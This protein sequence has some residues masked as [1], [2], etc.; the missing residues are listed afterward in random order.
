MRLVSTLSLALMLASGGVALAS[1]LDASAAAAQAAA[2]RL[3]MASAEDFA[4]I[5]GVDGALASRIV[6]LRDTRGGLGSV[7]ALRILNVPMDTLD[8]LRE[9][10]VVDTPILKAANRKTYD[11]VDQVM[12][13][14]TGEPEVRKVQAMAMNYSNTNP[15]LVEG[16]LASSRSAYL[17][18]KLN[19]KYQK[20]L[21]FNED[22]TANED[23]LGQFVEWANNSQD[24]DNNDTYE[25]KLEWR[26]DKLVMSS[27]RIR[28]INEAQDI[29]KLRD[30]VLDEVTR[31]YFDRRRLQVE[32]LLSPPSDLRTDIKKELQ[33]QELTANLD[34][35]TGGGFSASLP[36]GG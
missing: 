21:N 16:W 5:E 33:L 29:V 6:E 22:F 3:N 19:L 28:V 11:S 36:T 10:V 14:F 30:K 35:L 32:L 12:A 24:A 23:D 25:A 1:E 20:N 31:L 4:R 13:E 9:E 17:L 7:E 15:E 18:P 27:E 26:L 34:A 2:P 8:R